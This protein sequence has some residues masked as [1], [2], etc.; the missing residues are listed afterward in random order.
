[1]SHI[2]KNEMVFGQQ[3]TFKE[4]VRNIQAVTMDDFMRIAHRILDN[5]QF[6]LVTIGKLPQ[7]PINEFHLDL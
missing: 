4:I 3:F 5:A 7:N 1:M 2:A 6:S